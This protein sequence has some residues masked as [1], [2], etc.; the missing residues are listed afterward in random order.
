MLGFYLY[1]AGGELVEVSDFVRILAEV[2][3]FYSALVNQGAQAVIGLAQG[4]AQ[5]FCKLALG[6]IRFVFDDFKDFV[7]GGFLHVEYIRDYF[8]A[9]S[10]LVCSCGSFTHSVPFGGPRLAQGRVQIV[11]ICI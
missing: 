5:F 11:N 9:L 6:Q 7:F 2:F 10:V 8:R 3:R 4:Y 1:A